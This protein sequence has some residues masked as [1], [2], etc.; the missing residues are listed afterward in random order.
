MPPQVVKTGDVSAPVT[1]QAPIQIEETKAKEIDTK[2]QKQEPPKQDAETAA[3]NAAAAKQLAKDV[4]HEDTSRVQIIRN[5]LAQ[6]VPEKKAPV[7]VETKQNGPSQASQTAKDQLAEAI[8]KGADG[9]KILVDNE[10]VQAGP[11]PQQSPSQSI[12]NKPT[13]GQNTGGLADAQAKKEAANIAAED[14]RAVGYKTRVRAL[15]TDGKSVPVE[16]ALEIKAGK[17]EFRIL[18]ADKYPKPTVVPSDSHAFHK[19]AWET[20]GKSGNP[21]AAF[22]VGN[23]VRVDVEQLT[24]DQRQRF[25]ELDKAQN[26]TNYTKTHPHSVDP[27]AKTQPPS[28]DPH[29]KTQPPQAD[30][31]AKTQPPSVDPHGKT[32]AGGQKAASVAEK[33]AS[34]AGKAAASSAAKKGTAAGEAL[35]ATEKRAAALAATHAAEATGTGVKI[36]SAGSKVVQGLAHMSPVADA[37]FLEFNYFASYAEAHDI[38]RERNTEKG[39]AVGMAASLMGS[40]AKDFGL[41]AIDR[42]VVTQVLGAEGIAEKSH[43]KG[44]YDGY[45]YAQSLTT[46]ERNKLREGAFKDLSAKGYHTVNTNSFDKTDVIYAAG[47]MLP[48]VQKLFSETRKAAEA[49][50][51]RNRKEKNPSYGSKM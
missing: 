14:A 35:S 3:K 16:E 42:G 24:P 26:P 39:F 20:M 28:V 36:T 5:Q 13:G 30:P 6:R 31:H 44:V 1:P 19:T 51:L 23:Q 48:G 11:Q 12:R 25:I 38:I 37:I 22:T 21:P 17:S 46:E 43:N 34:A 18:P 50:A 15:P 27:H 7:N 45:K 8:A 29:A 10:P 40:P 49:E 47:A 33:E 4:I 41:N 9:P 32:Q 2:D